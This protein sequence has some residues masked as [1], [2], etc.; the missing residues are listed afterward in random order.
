VSEGC[1]VKEAGGDLCPVVSE[2]AVKVVKLEADQKFLLHVISEA[3][4]G[5]H[6]LTPSE[7]RRLSALEDKP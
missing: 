5:W 4:C 7:E 2:L 3:K 6:T 1:N